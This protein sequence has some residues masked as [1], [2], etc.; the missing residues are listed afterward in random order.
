LTWARIGGR[1]L[2]SAK[3]LDLLVAGGGQLDA[4]GEDG[5]DALMILSS[6][7]R[8]S[9]YSTCARWLMDAGA[10]P[11]RALADPYLEPGKRAV[12][13]AHPAAKR[14]LLRRVPDTDTPQERTRPPRTRAL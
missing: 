11:A 9:W 14:L 2:G 4:V 7:R 3:L 8:S 6:H 12:L 13:E 5:R 1:R 10:N